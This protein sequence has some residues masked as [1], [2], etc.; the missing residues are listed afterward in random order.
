MKTASASRGKTK[1]GA[2]IVA[3]FLL[4]GGLL[5]LL[6]SLFAVYHSAQR[7]QIFAGISGIL[8][9]ALFGWCIPAGAALWRT[10]PSGFKWAKLL[11]A[12]QVP[13]F[14][15]ARFSYE[16]STFFSFRVMIG[17]TTHYIGGNIG[18]SSNLNLLPESVGFLFGI[19]IAA[20]LILLYLIRAS[21]VASGKSLD[22][23]SASAQSASKQP[24]P[25]GTVKGSFVRNFRTKLYRLSL[26]LAEKVL[27]VAAA[28][29]S[30]KSAPDGRNRSLRREAFA[31]RIG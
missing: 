28:F 17:N 13:V 2:R 11:F 5:G 27:C 3:L 1:Y 6:G 14:S 26:L 7:H 10:K 15:I 31:E 18:S 20:V 16:F 12:I 19:N 29:F 4:A 22:R 23:A 8:A 21:R 30:T 24:R 9:T 25:L